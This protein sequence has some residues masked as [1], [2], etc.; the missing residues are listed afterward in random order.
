MRHDDLAPRRA[1]I[2][3]LCILVTVLGGLLWTPF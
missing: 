3:A 2:S 1:M